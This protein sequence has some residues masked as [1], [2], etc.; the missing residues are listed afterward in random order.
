M[1]YYAF[2]SGVIREPRTRLA[3][4]AQEEDMAPVKRLSSPKHVMPSFEVLV[5]HKSGRDELWIAVD[6]FVVPDASDD[7]KV[8]CVGLGALDAREFERVADDLIDQ[9]NEMKRLS[10]KHFASN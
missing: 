7:R 10:V 6:H 1:R 5:T 4:F 9:L 8:I 3:D 2:N